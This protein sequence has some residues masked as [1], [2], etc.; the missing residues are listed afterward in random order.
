M[1]IIRLNFD[2]Q[3][4]LIVKIAPHNVGRC[5]CNIHAILTIH[6]TTMSTASRRLRLRYYY[7]LLRLIQ[8]SAEYNRWMIRNIIV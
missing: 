8:L 3:S 7:Y 4:F 5:H 1:G 2:R 6:V